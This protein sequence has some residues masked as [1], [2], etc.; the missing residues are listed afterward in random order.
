MPGF[1][2][3]SALVAAA[4]GAPVVSL[5][6]TAA[7]GSGDLWPHLISYVLPQAVSD[8]LLLL[9]GTGVLVIVIGT[10]TAWLV[11]AY[12]FRGRALLQWALLLPL[13]M[14]TY[15]IA[16]AYLD[17]LHPIGPVQSALRAMLGIASPRGLILPDIRS[18]GGCIL[19]FGFVLFPYVYLT[20]RA[21]LLMQMASLVEVARTLG[22]SR[23]SIFHRVALPLARPAIA[24][25]AS[26]ALM[27]A[28]NDIGAAEFLGVRT[29][30]VSIYSTWVNRSNLPGAAQI[31]LIMLALV[32]AL[33][34]IE[35]AARRRQ[36]YAGQAQRARRLSPEPLHGWRA[37]LAFV[38]CAFPVFIG[39]VLPAS[40]LLVEAVARVRFAGISSS[41][42]AQAGNSMLISGVAT[43]VTLALG[44]T[45]A[46][47]ARSVRGPAAA[48]ILRIA[49]LGYAI[50]GTVLAL[51]LLGPIALID[52]LA[53]HI[54]QFFGRNT[55][56]LM[57]ASGAALIY[58][59]VAR[60]L[61]ISTGNVENGL[62]RLSYSLDHAAR[63][64]GETAG[65]VARRIH[66][67]LIS[68]ALAS[69]ALLVFVDC[70]K[71][72]PATLLLRPL[73]FE[74]LATHLYGEAARGTYEDGALAALAIVAFGL[75]PM[76]LLARYGQ[77]G[78]TL[79]PDV[80]VDAETVFT[81]VPAKAALHG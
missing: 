77:S 75:L 39:F 11:T 62:H 43:L 5:A 37:A 42:V 22:A 28:L 12:E 70:M 49:S 15:I 23:L 40:Y 20:T 61:T 27:D 60:F 69:A 78:K 18:M 58:A 47:T 74:T 71:E 10:L 1:L 72:L 4:V 46:F 53:F 14:P 29:M 54:G 35:R 36:S 52:D 50:P 45:L 25:G 6:V 63:T 44:V 7:R 24:V 80:A 33:I 41:L 68:P 16:Y 34:M 2:I 13:A 3:A 57:S 38:A 73:N 67:P 79:A 76:I 31:A 81:P 64:L 59:Y 51:G 8:T 55:G 66:L 17:L 32:V 21:M 26:L 30:T 48:F 19:L 56:L 65:G 9:A